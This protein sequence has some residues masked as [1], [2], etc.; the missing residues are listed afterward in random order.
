ML[1]EQWLEGS[2]SEGNTLEALMESITFA[3]GKLHASDHEPWLRT[4]A[5][6]GNSHI[7]NRGAQLHYYY[8]LTQLVEPSLVCEIGFNG[9]HSAATFLAAAP[10]RR[11][12]L[13]SFDL[14]AYT[15]SAT[16]ASLVSAAFPSQLRVISGSSFDTVP[17]FAQEHGRVCDLFSIDGDH[18]YA[19]VAADIRSAV[20]ATR[21]GGV[22]ILD[23]MDYATHRGSRLAFEHALRSGYV[24]DPVCVENVSIVVPWR[25]RFDDSPAHSRRLVASWCVA[26]APAQVPT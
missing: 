24:T 21:P 8:Q 22:V 6:A 3:L 16:A 15:Y 10:P 20:A 17:A 5:W 2:S 7:G 18:T 14:M 12:R 26:L 9:G 11:S 13:V 4:R 19:G 25:D 23:D 1:K